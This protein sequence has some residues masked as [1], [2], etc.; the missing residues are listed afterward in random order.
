MS[1]TSGSVYEE[2][3]LDPRRLQFAR[4]R[5]GGLIARIG[6]QEY[7]DLD[8]RRAFPLEVE[9]RFIGLFL[10]DGTEL[11]LLEDMAGLDDQSRRALQA[12]LDKVYFCPRITAIERIAEEHG[13]LRGQIQ[14]TSGPRQIE[15]RGWRE[16]VRLLS[17]NRAIV[18]DVDGNRYLIDDW[19]LLPKLTRQILGF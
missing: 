9:D 13:V 11:G 2:K 17:G 8:V 16:N 6:D 18:E 19:R 5:G 7:R 12:E 14:T 4:S 1:E 10:P 15:I 3:L